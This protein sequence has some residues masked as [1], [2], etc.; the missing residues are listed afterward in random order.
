MTETLIRPAQASDQEALG[1]YGA[2]LLRQHH[3]ADPRRFITAEHPEGAY[4]RFLV[5]QIANP[6]SVVLVAD[7]SGEVVGYVWA[8]LE[9]TSW[10]DLRGPCGFIQDVYV[11]QA[12]R[13]GGIGRKLLE[14]AIAWIRS[15]GMRQVVLMHKT[16]NEAAQR[17]FAHVGFRD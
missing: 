1:R 6:D 14:A 2:A 7:R 4:G 9:G 8:D 13:G 5:S 17:L 16:G 15:K 11:D 10:R 12:A 3:A